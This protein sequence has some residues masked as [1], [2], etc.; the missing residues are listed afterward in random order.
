MVVCNLAVHYFMSSAESMSRF[1]MLCRDLL[2]PG[3]M[4]ILMM[5]SG[6]RVFDKLGRLIQ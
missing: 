3:G 4:L 6:E 1:V 5:M 2:R